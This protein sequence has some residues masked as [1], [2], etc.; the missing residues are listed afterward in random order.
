MIYARARW[1]DA[2]SEAKSGPAVRTAEN[3]FP[4]NQKLKME[5][6]TPQKRLLSLDAFRGATMALMV[7]VNDPGGDAGYAQ[8]QH[9]HWNGWTMTD[10]VYPFFLW[11]VGVAMTFSIARRMEQG[12]NKK[13]L[14]R[15]AFVRAVI[16][17]VLGLIVN[18]FPFGLIFH[19][20]FSWAT[21]RIPGVLQRIAVCY[22]IA[23][24]IYLYS[25]VRG[26]VIWI[27]GL[28]A[29][30]WMLMKL[31][32][33][34]GFGAGFLEPKGNLQWY[35]DS[36][37][38]GAHT[39]TQAPASGFDPEGTLGTIT[40]IGTTLFGILTGTWLR[41]R[42]IPKEKKTLWML[43]AGILL[44]LTGLIFNI[45]LP[46]NK[47]MWTSSYAIFMAGWALI[48]LG[49]FFWLIDVKGYSKWA[50]VFVIF[51]MNA[52][53]V[54][55]FSELVATLLWIIPVRTGTGSSIPLHSYIYKHFF[56]PLGSPMNA[57]L[58][59]AVGYVLLSFAVAW[60]MWKRRWFLKV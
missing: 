46:I 27:I 45:W 11:I 60:I 12:E 29:G 37:I 14:I 57:S 15:H 26:L 5:N 7:L 4:I 28:L 9:A 22:F 25:N 18:N 34:P 50:M 47:N 32:P 53:A 31:V 3:E 40:A 56:S 59:F 17:F 35:F 48:V 36:R 2:K 39:Y 13:V 52:I 21:W 23:T 43:M 30:Y 1:R 54:Y 58:L 20:Q 16:L 8:L 33:V 24:V 51:G 44:V 42:D 6:V 10:M 19:S 38:F 55:M 41:R 49:L